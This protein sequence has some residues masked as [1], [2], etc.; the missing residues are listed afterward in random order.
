MGKTIK[1]DFEGNFGDI[2]GLLPEQFRR[3]FQPQHPD[4]T[5][6]GKAGQPP[7]FAM[8]LHPAQARFARKIVYS[9]V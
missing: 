6:G 1:A 7:Q 8:K 3:P 5:A 9:K 4:K 2:A